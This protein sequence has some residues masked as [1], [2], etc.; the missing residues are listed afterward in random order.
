VG[1]ATVKIITWPIRAIRGDPKPEAKAVARGHSEPSGPE[2]VI[3]GHLS[4]ED[5]T[6]KP[7]AGGGA[8]EPEVGPR[9]LAAE[10]DDDVR[11]R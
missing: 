9:V 4:T 10:P 7:K 8:S 11:L 1:K 6:R 3:A 2:P 5:R